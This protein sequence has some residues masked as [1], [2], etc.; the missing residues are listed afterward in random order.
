[1][2]KSRGI[3]K[4]HNI[5][6]IIT[7]P[8][9]TQWKV[10]VDRKWIYI[11][12]P[13]EHFKKYQPKKK[14]VNNFPPVNLPDHI[15]PTKYPHY[16]VSKYGVAYREPRQCDRNGS[17]G[18]VNE[19]GLIQLNTQLRGNPN[20]GEEFRYEGTNIYLYDENGKNIGVK[21]VNIHQLVAQVWIPNPH[22]YTE[23]LHGKE[24]NRCNHYTNLRWGTHKDNMKEA[25]SAAPEGTIRYH[26]R[27]YAST[28]HKRNPTKYR[29]EN[30]E[31]VLIP[32]TAPVWN[33]GL[34]GCSW[35]TLPDGT[36]RTRKVN[37]S[38]EKFIKQNGEWV[39]QKK[40]KAPDGTIRTHKNGRKYIK[41]NGEWVYQRKERVAQ[42]F[43]NGSYLNLKVNGVYPDGAIRTRSDG[44]KWKKENGKW[45]YQKKIKQAG[46]E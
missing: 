2:T 33:K 5:G 42:V 14:W 8:D 40:E 26:N 21:K 10:G 9:G 27:N 3:R 6:D 45:V 24:G 12:K 11:R 37:G 43:E 16:Y 38:P 44:T 20:Y 18:E 7:R 17:Y 25:K 28:G 13:K 4:K 39:Y 32:S 15:K 31:W 23:V 19:W 36:V 22:G 35:N 29:K 30:G 46:L 34:K 1:M 41:E